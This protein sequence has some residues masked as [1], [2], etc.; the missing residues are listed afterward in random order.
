MS[1]FRGNYEEALECTKLATLCAPS[2]P[3]V[4]YDHGLSFLFLN[5][6]QQAIESF[7]TC[8]FLVERLKEETYIADCWFNKGICFL[9]MGDFPNAYSS[10]KKALKM[11]PSFKEVQDAIKSIRKLPDVF[12]TEFKDTMDNLFIQY[13]E[14]LNE[15]LTHLNESYLNVTLSDDEKEIS[16]IRNTPL[17]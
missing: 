8:I 13:D 7:D 1:L 12:F 14:S 17:F 16:E 6:W 15:I 5:K 11:D 2:E 3:S 4:W 9:S 10:Y